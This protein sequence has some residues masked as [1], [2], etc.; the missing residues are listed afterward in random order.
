MASTTYNTCCGLTKRPLD[1]ELLASDAAGLALRKRFALSTLRVSPSRL[2]PSPPSKP[3][4][5][6]STRRLLVALSSAYSHSL[7]PPPI[8][9]YRMPPQVPS[10]HCGPSSL[11]ASPP[12]QGQSP[13]GTS[14]P[15]HGPSSPSTSPIYLAKAL[16]L[17]RFEDIMHGMPMSS[18]APRGTVESGSDAE[19]PPER[20]GDCFAI[21]LFSEVFATPD[22]VIVS[23][24]PFRFNV[25]P[26]A[27][28]AP[29]DE[30]AVPLVRMAPPLLPLIVRPGD[31]GF[32]A[33]D[34]TGP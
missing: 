24:E 20:I 22:L 6:P 11:S 26:L 21:P 30:G 10:F 16:N 7:P 33:L 29:P 3:C 1:S 17:L 2:R 4:L 13:A 31:A 32:V 14:T 12:V 19:A 15:T 23:A 28:E 27:F 5:D 18:V 8:S 9:K 25:D 34:A